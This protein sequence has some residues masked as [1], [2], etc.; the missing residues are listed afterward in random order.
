MALDRNLLSGFQFQNLNNK[1]FRYDYQCTN[2]DQSLALTTVE[3]EWTDYLGWNPDYA[4][5]NGDV[6]FLDRQ[7]VDCSGSGG[8]LASLSMEVNYETKT[9][10]YF[11]QCGMPANSHQAPRCKDTTTPKRDSENFFLP[12]LRHHH[13]RCDKNAFLQKFY[14]IVDYDQPRGH[15]WY[16]YTCCTL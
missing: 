1:K 8:L 2:V 5:S 9:L 11:Y 4:D 6:N 10:R 3:N 15:V 16:H 13:V 7:T 12:S 14:I